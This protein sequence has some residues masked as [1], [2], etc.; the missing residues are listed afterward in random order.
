MELLQGSWELDFKGYDYEF[1]HLYFQMF[2]FFIL[3]QGGR[4]HLQRLLKNC[5]YTLIHLFIPI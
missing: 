3:C 4:E 2:V 5:Q 1:Y